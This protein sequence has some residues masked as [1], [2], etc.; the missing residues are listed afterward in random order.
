MVLQVKY[1][2]IQ[3]HS[4]YPE[5]KEKPVQLDA[6]NTD[7]KKKDFISLRIPILFFAV[8]AVFLGLAHSWNTVHGYILTV[9]FVFHCF[10]THKKLL[11]LHILL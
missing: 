1:C 4:L 6:Q 7:C 9:S 8:L 5:T 10:I 2:L 3:K 11:W